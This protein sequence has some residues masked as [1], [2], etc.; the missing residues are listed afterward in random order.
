MDQTE[1]IQ[2]KIIQ[3]KDV[4]KEQTTVTGSTQSNKRNLIVGSASLRGKR[5]KNEDTHVTLTS[6]E[7][8][9]T[10]AFFRCL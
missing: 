2:S 1:S 5:D 8:D 7:S 4:Q 6:M 10:T 9:P 3:D